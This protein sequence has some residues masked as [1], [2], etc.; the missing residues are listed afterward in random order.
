MFYNFKK[1]FN[2]K[3]PKKII[4]FDVGANRGDWSVNIR[5][6]FKNSFLYC[7]EPIPKITKKINNQ[8]IINKAIDIT[9]N[10]KR[11][12]YITR[13]FVTSSMLMQNRKI[14]SKFKSFKDKKG[15]VHKKSDFDVIKKI[16]VETLRLDNFIKKYN[17]KN[18]HYLKID[19]EGNDL[20]VLKSLGKSLP[21]VWAFELETWNEKKTLWKNQSWLGECKKFIL[22]N[23]FI[24]A[25]E[26]IHGK[27]RTTDLLCIRKDIFKKKLLKK[28]P[29]IS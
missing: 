15:K 28:H 12:F 11:N 20:Q 5:K 9:E 1:Y 27:G 17:I 23:N 6:K 26:F 3:F 25:E 22:S 16:T 21:K 24:I 14:I 4:F 19:A 2:K 8:I 13:E 29:C 18:I 7:F 10:N